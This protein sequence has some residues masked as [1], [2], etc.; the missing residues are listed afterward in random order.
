MQRYLEI[1]RALRGGRDVSQEDIKYFAS[2]HQDFDAGQ[3]EKL[4]GKLASEE[5]LKS[6]TDEDFDSYVNEA[7]K[8]LTTGK[9]KEDVIDIAKQAEA[10]KVAAKVTTGLNTLLA[11]TDIAISLGQI[12]KANQQ[13]AGIKRPARPAVLQRDQDLAQA[14]QEAH[15][16]TLDQSAALQPARLANL[17]TYKADLAQGA[18]ASE[19]QPGAYG[20][21]GQAAAGR[22]YRANAELVPLGNEIKRQEQGRYDQLLGMRQQEGQAINQSQSQFYPQDL[23]QYGIDRQA[24]ASLGQTGRSNLRDSLTGLAA[25]V[26]AIGQEFS[27]RRYDDIYNQMSAY[28]HEHAQ[29][30]ADAW[31]DLNDIHQSNQGY[32]YGPPRDM[33][34]KAFRF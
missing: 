8:M 29:T 9:Y 24:A 11:G 23:Y 22:M 34:D 32:Q 26:P 6:M 15:R 25:Q 18:I 30:A 16:G 4:K 14:L 5:G 13:L 20:A 33:Y 3:Y 27:N 19:G 28:G 21:Y 31:K 17:D 10:G 12:G 1:L 2:F 7:R